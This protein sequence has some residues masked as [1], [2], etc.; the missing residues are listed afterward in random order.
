VA[1]IHCIAKGAFFGAVTGAVKGAASGA[2][3]GAVKALIT[4]GGKEAIK[5]GALDGAASGFMSGAI[6]GA[7][8]GALTSSYCFIAGTAVLAAAGYVLIEDIQVGD[9]VWS[10]NESENKAEIKE[11]VETYVNETYELTHI[12]VDGEE[13]VSTPAHPYYSPGKGWVKAGDLRAGDVL[14]TVNGE[15]KIVEWVQ[16]EI[17]ESPVLV[18]NF[19]V[20]GNHTYYVAFESI[21][22]HNSCDTERGLRRQREANMNNHEKITYN[23]RDRIP[24]Y[25]MRDPETNII[26]TIGEAKSVR[27]LS[28]SPQLI[29]MFS[30]GFENG[31]KMFIKIERWTRLSKPLLQMLQEYSVSIGVF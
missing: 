30:Y 13:I 28:K 10:W 9:E 25:L 21:S 26:K 3:A 11:V 4:G 8:T 22:V 17:L 2:V 5:Q 19:Q 31:C 6:T 23:G 24:D 14:V 18:Y 7:I 27:Y 20:D 15:Y 29:D 16:H 12:S 1:A